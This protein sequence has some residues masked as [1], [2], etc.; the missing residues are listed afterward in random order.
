M[1]CKEHTAK[2]SAERECDQCGIVQPLHAYSARSRKDEDWYCKRCVAWTETQESHVVPIPLGSGH[3]SVEEEAADRWH[4]PMCQE[5]FYDQKELLKAEIT[6]PEGLGI[7]PSDHSMTKA[8][9]QVVGS[10]KSVSTSADRVT[11]SETSSIVGDHMSVTSSRASRSH[12]PP[13]L[14]GRLEKLEL[15]ADTAS[16]GSRPKTVST[17]S[18]LPPHLRGRMQQSPSGSML[19]PHQGTARSMAG[20]I[21][22]ATTLRKDQE[23]ANASRQITYNAWDS[24]GQKHQTVKNPTVASSSTSALSTTG[25]NDYNDPNTGG[26]WKDSKWPK[27][28]EPEPALNSVYGRQ[29]IDRAQK[30]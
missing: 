25:D 10:S 18:A 7:D 16:E 17:S 15:N 24:N 28:S 4:Q 14:L 26:H 21:S 8:Y 29:R 20:S 9:E 12:V 1:I 11:A 30:W 6:G 13:H 3:V 22:T 19:Q 5:D 27:A 2:I 23:M